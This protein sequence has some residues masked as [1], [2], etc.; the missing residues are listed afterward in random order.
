MKI[1][2]NLFI[3]A[4]LS[5]LALVLTTYKCEN[6]ENNKTDKKQQNQLMKM[7]TQNLLRV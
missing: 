6:K 7:F 1:K 4:I 3:I 5:S 2:I